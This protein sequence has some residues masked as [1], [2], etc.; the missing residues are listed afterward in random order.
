[1]AAILTAFIVGM[2]IG[3]M[4]SLALRE[5]EHHFGIIDDEEDV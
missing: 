4:L 5:W 2:V 3:M 1:M